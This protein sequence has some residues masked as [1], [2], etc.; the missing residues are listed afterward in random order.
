MSPGQIPA[1]L[2]LHCCQQ[3]QRVRIWT[4]ALKILCYV[5]RRALQLGLNLAHG[6]WQLELKWQQG[7]AGTVGKAG[8]LTQDKREQ[9]AEPTMGLWTLRF[10]HSC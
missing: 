2:D 4:Q 9:K 5:L 1:D 8:S 6:T 3:G 7:L 10:T